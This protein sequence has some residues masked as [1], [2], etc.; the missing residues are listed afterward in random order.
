VTAHVVPPELTDDELFQ[1]A[2]RRPA[3]DLLAE[4]I[5][6]V[7]AELAANPSVTVRA[8][9][10][11]AGVVACRDLGASDVVRDAFI[12]L[13]ADSGLFDQ[14]AA[15]QPHAPAATIDH[16]IRWGMLDRDPFGKSK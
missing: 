11:W 7:C 4:G 10:L 2:G 5:A 12:R 3:V 13:A 9:I 16:L 8:R 14:L 6:H 15:L 1:L